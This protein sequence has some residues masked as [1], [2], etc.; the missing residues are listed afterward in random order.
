MYKYWI[1]LLILIAP[2]VCDGQERK[3]QK[4]DIELGMGITFGADSY[5]DYEN[6][7]GACL[8]LEGRY[9]FINFPIN[10][11]IQIA[12]CAI[13]REDEIFS[14]DVNRVSSLLLIGDYQFRRGQKR[15]NP[16]AGLGLGPVWSE[17]SSS[18][19]ACV[20]PRI[21]VRFFNHINLH[22]DYK[23]AKT[24]DRHASLCLGFYF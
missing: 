18:T 9:N 16:Y 3:H 17:L 2:V 1:L 4:I 8:K 13:A 22:L 10:I 6:R 23:F 5:Y 7:L 14:D 24:A 20:A 12:Q 19:Y 15:V 11:G 21:G